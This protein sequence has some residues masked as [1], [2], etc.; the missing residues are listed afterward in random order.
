MVRHM[1]RTYGASELYVPK[2]SH[3]AEE[4]HFAF[5]GKDLFEFVQAAADVSHVDCRSSLAHP[6]TE[7]SEEFLSLASLAPRP[8][9]PGILKSIVG[10]AHHSFV[11]FQCIENGW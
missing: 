2:N 4:I 11:A 6:G 5:I 1:I 10:T 8:L 7:Q 3:D 9:F